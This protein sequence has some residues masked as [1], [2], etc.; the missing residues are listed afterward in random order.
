MIL[1]LPLKLAWK[2]IFANKG[3]TVLTLIGIVIGIAVVIIVMSAGEGL[4]SM[5]MG[6]VEVFGNDIVQIETKV[7]SSK[8]VGGAM[9]MAQGVQIT[10]LKLSDA[11][12]IMKLSN[13]KNYYALVIGQGVVSHLEQNKIANYMGVSPSIIEID[14]TKV[15]KGR[16]FTDEED[17]SLARVVVLGS[18]LSDDLFG[19]QDPIGQRIKLGKNKFTVIG[20]MEK[21]GSSFGVSF[22]DFA[23]VPIQTAQKLMLGINHV[24]SLVMQ[25]ENTSIQEQTADEIISVMRERHNIT[26]P[27]DDDFQVTTME[28]VRE[29]LDTIFGGITLLLVALAGISLLVGGIGIMNIMYVSVTERTFE[30]GLR[31]SIGARKKQ[32]LWQFLWEAI[33]VTIVGGIIGI[34]VGSIISFLVYLIATRLNY[35]WE[36]IVPPQAIIISFVFCAS[37]GLLFGYWPAKKAAKMDPI[38][39]MRKE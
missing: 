19:N 2:S 25:M 24:M 7:P 33:L 27:N 12:E 10:S 26:D 36:F 31:K 23:Y 22:D 20:V 21:R 6:Q 3:R 11:E 29:M 35:P 34:I 9:A 15:E 8:T 17:N 37:V 38:S 28:E 30:I 13:I 1:N 32:I 4:K 14:K 18:S 5:V 16:F 39:A